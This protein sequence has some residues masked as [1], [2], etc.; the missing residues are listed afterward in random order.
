MWQ[1]S[2]FLPVFCN[3]FLV[4][5][6]PLCPDSPP[7]LLRSK[8]EAEARK[9]LCWLRKGASAETVEA[10]LSEMYEESAMGNG[11]SASLKSICAN[12][13]L[14]M[15][16]LVGTSVNLSM[17]L[18]G[19]D[20]VLYYSTDV[21]EKAGISEEWSQVATTLVGL[22]NVLVTIPAMLLMDSMGRKAIQSIGLGG[23]CL[24]YFTIT[25]ALVNGWYMLSVVSM[26]M[27]I[28]FFAFGPGCIGWFIVSEL[29]PI[30]ARS[31]GTSLG[32]G[33]NF[34]ANWFVGF[35]FPFIHEGLGNWCY[36]VFLLSTFVL[37]VFTLVCVPETKGKSVAEVSKFF[38]SSKD[39]THGLLA[40][41]CQPLQ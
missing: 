4:I 13:L 18:S 16:I 22:V 17:Q 23:M 28:V 9:A 6:L 41:A 29:T 24:S 3:T 33:A 20:G 12:R 37:T 35:V 2:F 10:E 7:F 39:L 40:S 30:H 26:V 25:V 36:T 31:V 1:Y 38:E 15:P 19:I 21:F 5:G 11:K 8:G 14:W 34:F 32:L 27:I